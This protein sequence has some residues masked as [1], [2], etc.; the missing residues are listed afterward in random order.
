MPEKIGPAGASTG[1][2]KMW[3]R[4]ASPPPDWGLQRTLVKLR[5][6]ATRSYCETFIATSVCGSWHCQFS[7]PVET[8]AFTILAFV[9]GLLFYAACSGV[10]AL[11]LDAL[12]SG[13]WWLALLPLALFHASAGFIATVG[14]DDQ[15]AG[16]TRTMALYGA[17]SVASTLFTIF[18]AIWFA[19]AIP[20]R[21]PYATA[22]VVILASVLVGLG[23]L[24]VALR[25]SGWHAPRM[26]A[27]HS[28][29][30]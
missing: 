23:G 5:L 20:L 30:N 19:R 17:A 28:L 26:R 10:A 13:L 21:F 14:S 15:L 3:R 9:F 18:I 22:V 4:L 11:T 6:A 29:E 27:R 16:K 12:A 25:M 8:M 2:M 24:V 7:R 1:P